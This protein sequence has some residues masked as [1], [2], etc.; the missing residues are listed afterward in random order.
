MVW[1]APSSK[2]LKMARGPKSLATPE[3]DKLSRVPARKSASR[4]RGKDEKN[5]ADETWRRTARTLLSTTP[6]T[7][8]SSKAS[9]GRWLRSSCSR[10]KYAR[11]KATW[12]ESP[13]DSR[14]CAFISS[15]IIEKQLEIIFGLRI[16]S[17]YCT[18]KSKYFFEYNKLLSFP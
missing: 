4:I 11:K 1:P 5:G 9:A 17:L 2:F 12:S 6:S 13:S 18:K 15:S 14:D 10:K 3:L 7:T 16:V 8:P